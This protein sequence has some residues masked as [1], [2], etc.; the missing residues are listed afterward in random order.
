[1]LHEYIHA[2]IY[3]CFMLEQLFDNIKLLQEN[4]YFYFHVSIPW[5]NFEISQN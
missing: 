4:L 2:L 5:C 1:M 3:V